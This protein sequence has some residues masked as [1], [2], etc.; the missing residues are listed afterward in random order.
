ME[1]ALDSSALS[2][3]PSC[4]SYEDPG[5]RLKL[6]CQTLE[7]EQQTHNLCEE[8]QPLHPLPHHNLMAGQC[9]VQDCVVWLCGV[10]PWPAAQ[11]RPCRAQL[12]PE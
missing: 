4:P 11:P 12:D 1:V 7:R 6:G 9:Q 10:A 8:P 3:A 5:S 2:S